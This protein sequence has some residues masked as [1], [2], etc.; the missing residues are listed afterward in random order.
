MQCYPSHVANLISIYHIVQ[1]KAMWLKYCMSKVNTCNSGYGLRM[2]K[3]RFYRGTAGVWHYL[4]KKTKKGSFFLQN[5]TNNS[6]IVQEHCWLLWPSFNFQFIR[7]HFE[8][9]KSSSKTLRWC[10]CDGSSSRHVPHFYAVSWLKTT[11]LLYTAR[12]L[13]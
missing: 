9:H 7:K 12:R 4:C 3:V 1:I 8:N 2:H 13:R 11:C 10:S 6:I 5:K